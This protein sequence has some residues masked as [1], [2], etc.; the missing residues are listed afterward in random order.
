MIRTNPKETFYHSKENI[1]NVFSEL[2]NSLH[3]GNY[4]LLGASQIP[5]STFALIT[6]DSVEIIDREYEE[7]IHFSDFRSEAESEFSDDDTKE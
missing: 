1:W 2:Q 7:R 3:R 4:Y 6:M 5:L